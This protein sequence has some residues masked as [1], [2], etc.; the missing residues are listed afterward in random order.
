MSWTIKRKT[1]NRF[2]Q[3]KTEISSV[4]INNWKWWAEYEKEKKNVT[5]GGGKKLPITFYSYHEESHSIEANFWLVVTS[6]LM[7][8]QKE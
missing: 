8:K 5:Y 7:F 6:T 3:N 2:L 4:W 1:T